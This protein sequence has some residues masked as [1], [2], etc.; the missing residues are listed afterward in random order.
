M[1]HQCTICHK[2]F[3]FVSKLR[4][5]Q[6]THSGQRPFTCCICLKSFRQSAHLKG[7]LKSH[8]RLREVSLI[9]SQTINSQISYIKTE[10]SYIQHVGAQVSEEDDVWYGSLQTGSGSECE[11]QN[12]G[13]LL[14]GSD[15][16]MCDLQGTDVYE[17]SPHDEGLQSSQYT[18]STTVLSHSA[19]TESCVQQQQQ[20][21]PAIYISEETQKLNSCI[22]EKMAK[23]ASRHQ[24]SVCLKCFSAPS[25]LKRHVLIHSSFRPFC[26]EFCPKAFRQLTHLK[27]HQSTHFSHRQKEAKDVIP[28]NAGAQN[29]SRT[30]DPTN[31]VKNRTKPS[32]E[33][34]TEEAGELGKEP[35]GSENVHTEAFPDNVN[36]VKSSEDRTT[37][38]VRH[39]CP[40]CQKCFSAPSKLRRHCLS[41]TGQRPFQC[42]LCTRAFRQ[43]SHLKAHQSVHSSPRNTLTPFL[44]MHRSLQPQPSTHHA[45]K[46]RLKRFVHIS[47]ARKYKAAKQKLKISAALLSPSPAAKIS[48]KENISETGEVESSP[49]RE[50]SRRQ[51]YSCSVCLKHFNAPSKLRRHVLIHTG[52]RPFRCT[53][54]FRGFRQKSHLQVH[55]C[56]AG[57]RATLQSSVR[58]VHLSDAASPRSTVSITN[59]D[60]HFISS[61]TGDDC[62]SH[63][64]GH[65]SQSL[66]EDAED[67]V[68]LSYEGTSKPSV[69]THQAEESGYQCTICFKIFD[70]PSKL[71]RHLLI[72][73]NIKPFKC[74]VC[75][76]SFRQL[77]H[78]QSH[79]RVHTVGKNMLYQGTYKNNMGTFI[80]ETSERFSESESE[81]LPLAQR[82]DASF[83]LQNMNPVNNSSLSCSMKIEEIT[84]NAMSTGS[85]AEAH[86]GEDSS[87]QMK[88]NSNQCIFCLKTF[89]F[90]S[91]LSR[92]L[93]VHTGIRP[94]ECHVCFKSFK[95]LSHLQCHQW[96]H[97]KTNK[98]EC[99]AGMR[100]HQS[101]SSSG[102]TSLTDEAESSECVAVVYQGHDGYTVQVEQQRWISE[103]NNCCLS[104]SGHDESKVKSES[105]LLVDEA[106]YPT[107]KY[108]SDPF[109][110]DGTSSTIVYKCLDH[111]AGKPENN[112][113]KH[114]LN[115]TGEVHPSA[116]DDKTIRIPDWSGVDQQDEADPGD[117][118]PPAQKNE[119]INVHNF[120]ICISEDSFQRSSALPDSCDFELNHPC[121]DSKEGEGSN[122]LLTEPPNDL[123]ICP[124]CSQCFDSVQKL[125]THIYQVHCPMQ[126]LSKSYQCA[127][128]FKSFEAPSKLKRHYVIHTGQRPYR[129]N[130]CD[131]DFTQSSHLKT[132]M[133]SH[134]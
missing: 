117:P 38:K 102:G 129:C 98:S 50:L 132:H 43:L 75:S 118:G 95:Q 103:D 100:S 115:R 4:R 122:H 1:T 29:P 36:R 34:W 84:P 62:R 127:V 45:S 22:E 9:V 69:D 88:R 134:R 113:F 35:N 119:G 110:S 106:I 70:F 108:D 31:A 58:E 8:S 55:K 71:S 64:V 97:N 42:S 82:P 14:I 126:R 47:L 85:P 79:S 121:H 78:L 107:L 6:L 13:K 63:G 96:V 105:D 109:G 124:S 90:P 27:V 131:K 25:K 39:E 11:S 57:S 18:E 53:D 61:G 114:H 59:T 19:N 20:H 83:D 40:L 3:D 17:D 99:T 33:P 133:L 30:L 60:D 56:K 125:S 123:P 91:K 111:E 65:A 5:H 24:C 112:Y 44:Q 2:H 12:N 16:Q 68:S 74:S 67:R 77:S 10:E 15:G 101:P 52:Q 72:H 32:K 26:C 92:H 120:P 41:H 86:K 80:P 76:K 81:K 89:D 51:D 128:C 49:D 48:I 73:M 21:L 104:V 94:Y 46:A 7:H 28:V 54:C 116:A 87:S 23:R 37:S 66:P 93:L 130:V